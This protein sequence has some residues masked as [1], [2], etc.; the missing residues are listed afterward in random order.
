MS[1]LKKN[2]VRNRKK[3]LG[4]LDHPIWSGA[5][6]AI[7]AAL[8]GTLVFFVMNEEPESPQ[9]AGDRAV[10]TTEQ[11]RVHKAVTIVVA[12]GTH[13]TVDGAGTDSDVQIVL[14]KG[15]TLNNSM[16]FDG[17]KGKDSI[18]ERGGPISLQRFPESRKLDADKVRI[19][20]LK[21]KGDGGHWNG[22]SIQITS[23][24]EDIDLCTREYVGWLKNGS[25]SKT[26]KLYPCL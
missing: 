15:N 19:T 4:W 9:T 21:P 8:I 24:E 22:T 1:D 17:G 18:L 11:P 7:I 10:N 20:L 6:G 23:I 26:L 16:L 2:D 14:F 3:K 13:K 12:L 5:A 25:N